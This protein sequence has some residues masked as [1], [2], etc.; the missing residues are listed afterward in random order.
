[1]LFIISIRFPQIFKIGDILDLTLGTLKTQVS[2]VL[3]DFDKI[4]FR[5][6]IDNLT[7]DPNFHFFLCPQVSFS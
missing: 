2:L 5:K 6:K 1:M 4:T 3:C 7:V